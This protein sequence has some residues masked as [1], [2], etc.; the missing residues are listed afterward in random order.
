[1][2]NK[3]LSVEQMDHLK[4]LGVDISGASMVYLTYQDI[5]DEWIESDDIVSG[6]FKIDES[7]D[8]ITVLEI[9]SEDIRLWQ[10]M[11][12]SSSY[13]CSKI[14]PTLTLPDIFNLLPTRIGKYNLVSDCHNYVAYKDYIASDD[15]EDGTNR[16][17]VEEDILH[18]ECH[19]QL[20]I[21]SYEMLCWLYE[22]KYLPLKN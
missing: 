11:N 14:N 4:E 1:M 18:S 21:A 5:T 9:K 20:I 22:H 7:S 13:S 12:E 16:Y 8:P 6:H 3:V 2:E 19:K 10:D 15:E 17:V